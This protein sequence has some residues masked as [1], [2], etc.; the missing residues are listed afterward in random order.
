MVGM[1]TNESPFLLMQELEKR[2]KGQLAALDVY[3]LP[4]EERK[5]VTGL[6]RE[7]TDARLDIRDYELSETREAQL[8]CAK[9]AQRRLNHIQKSILESSE[10]NVFGAADVAHLTAQLEYISGRIV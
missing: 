7:L 3:S 5:L 10:Y 6:R 4:D 2:L 1:E 8:A 9:I